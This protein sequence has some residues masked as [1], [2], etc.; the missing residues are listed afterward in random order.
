VSNNY[1]KRNFLIIFQHG[2]TG[3]LLVRMRRKNH[4]GPRRQNWNAIFFSIGYLAANQV[5]IPAMQH[6]GMDGRH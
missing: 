3:K 2:Q 4:A 1:V 6:V 5:R